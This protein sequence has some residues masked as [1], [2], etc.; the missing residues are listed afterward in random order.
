VAR[1]ERVRVC[2]IPKGVIHRESNPGD[3]ESVAVVVRL[4]AG[5]PVVNVDRPE[6]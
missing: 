2:H 5:V 1:T 6:G 4:G 3:E